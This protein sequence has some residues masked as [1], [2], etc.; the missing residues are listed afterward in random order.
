MVSDCVWRCGY[1]VCHVFRFITYYLFLR[2]SFTRFADVYTTSC[3]AGILVMDSCLW[4][5]VV[6]REH[7]SVWFATSVPSSPDE[8]LREGRAQ[9]PHMFEPQFWGLWCETD[10]QMCSGCLLLSSMRIP[11]L[12]SICRSVPLAGFRRQGGSQHWIR[13][14]KLSLCIV[15]HLPGIG[16]H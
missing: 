7:P 11:R 9:A 13:R 14:R 8:A 5:P 10:L 16:L 3:C 1:H 2:P 4:Y 12:V 6:H 15:F